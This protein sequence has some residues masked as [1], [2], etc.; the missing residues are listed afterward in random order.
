MKLFCLF[1]LLINI[2]FFLWEY[3]KGA[4]D[5]YQPQPIAAR[6]NG[7]LNKQQIF[8]LSELPPVEN[9]TE[10]V[11]DIVTAVV[12]NVDG[13]SP[14]LELDITEQTI[15]GSEALLSETNLPELKSDTALSIY[16]A[17]EFIPPLDDQHGLPTLLTDTPVGQSDPA[18]TWQS[19]KSILLA[20]N[21]SIDSFYQQSA[22]L[23]PLKIVDV[24]VAVAEK[25]PASESQADFIGPPLPEDLPIVA[26]ASAH[27]QQQAINVELTVSPI[28]P[29]T[30]KEQNTA[31]YLLKKSRYKKEML[32]L[33]SS[34]SRYQLKFLDQEQEYISSYLVLTKAA[35]SLSVAKERVALIKDQG[36]K[37]LWLFRQGEFKWRISLG[38]F[39][40]KVKAIKARNNYARQITQVLNIAPSV[41]KKKITLVSV[42]SENQFMTDFES[43][44]SVFIDQKVSCTASE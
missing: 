34:D 11:A 21:S 40:T 29:N 43:K 6:T 12:A 32:V 16:L 28:Q 10:Q 22:D 44:F 13:V 23:Q 5:I 4:P 33:A 26:E 35:G 18:L 8:L 3:R 39:S 36:I 17:T 15:T 42:T 24:G 31:C 41:R 30:S 19:S 25:L 14:D 1:I 20:I 2:S 37:E 27:Q 7:D 9:N 38:L